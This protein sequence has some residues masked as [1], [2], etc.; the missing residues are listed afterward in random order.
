[1]A[2]HGGSLC[3]KDRAST[4]SITRDGGLD[5]EIYTRN[6]TCLNLPSALPKFFYH[7]RERLGSLTKSDVI[8]SCGK[9]CIGNRK[10]EGKLYNSI[11]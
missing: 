1:M 8:L 3:S 2:V 11:D 9:A 4:E 6:Q 7:T 10:L 5:L